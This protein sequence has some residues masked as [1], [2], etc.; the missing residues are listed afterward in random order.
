MQ[1]LAHWKE[2]MRLRYAGWQLHSLA[3]TLRWVDRF[4][5]RVS[6]LGIALLVLL[7]IT[8]IFGVNIK[9]TMIYQLFTLTLVMMILSLF[10]LRLQSWMQKRECTL[11]RT[12]ADYA[13]V[14]TSFTYYIHIT[15]QSGHH[16][17]QLRLSERMAVPSPSLQQFLQMR[18]PEEEKRNVYDRKMGYYRFSWLVRWLQGA[19][20]EPIF[21]QQLK[22]DEQHRVAVSFTPMRRGYIHLSNLRLSIAEPLGLFYRFQDYALPHSILVLPKRYEIPNTLQMRGG[23]SYQRN[24]MALASNVGEPEEFNRMRE[25]RVGDSPRHIHWP[26]L[27]R[28]GK[29]QVKEYEEERFARQVLL[30]DNFLPHQDHEVFEEAVSLAAGFAMQ[31]DSDDSLLDLMFVGGGSAEDI[32][33]GRALAHSE[34]ML[35][36]LALLEPMFEDD[37]EHLA[38]VL[39]NQAERFGAVIL[40]L[41]SWNEARMELVR[42]LQALSVSVQVFLVLDKD[43]KAPEAGVGYLHALRVGAI[44]EG[45]HAIAAG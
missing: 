14:G 35:E 9:R 40:V 33:A 13:T 42:E 18:E 7:L 30:L 24:G 31:V 27:A 36:A 21:L 34:Q 41:L 8:L 44:E 25:Y 4:K 10:V 32:V 22:I 12:I 26:S 3:R 43:A 11:S 29:W 16:L 37:F 39:I 23:S 20:I 15:N 5:Q 38:Q 45:L 19:D 6:V 17:S 1:A 28:G 2:G